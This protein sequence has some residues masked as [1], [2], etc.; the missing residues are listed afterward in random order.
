[1]GR[2]ENK[3]DRVSDRL[4]G[5]VKSERGYERVREGGSQRE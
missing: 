3:K 1:M 5:L 4:I 2:D